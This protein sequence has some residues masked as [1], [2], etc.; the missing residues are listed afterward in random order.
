MRVLAH[1]HTF[2]EAAFIEQA[3]E[4]LQRQTRQPDAVI[5]V[6]NGST[7]GTVERTFPENVTVIINSVNLG[8]SG[9]VGVGF[10]Y[11]LKHE[12]DWI[13]V[14]DADSLP[15]SGV[16]REPARLF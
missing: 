2:N 15:E 1:I 5:I 13:W 12:F 11:A 9:S 4:G 7:D 6:D 3:L 14:L 8:T 16:P 10:A